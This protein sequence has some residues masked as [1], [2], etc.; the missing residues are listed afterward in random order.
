MN[1][2]LITLLLSF[3]TLV[4]I[5]VILFNNINIFGFINPMIYLL[6]LVIFRFDSDQTLF[7][8][9]CFI[10]GFCID[11][12]SQSGGAH[13]IASLTTGFLRPLLI[14]Y[15]FGVTSEIPSTFQNDSRITNKFLFLGLLIGIHHLLYFIIV[16]FNWSA[17][18]L[19][20]KNVI[21][22]SLFSLILIALVSNFYKKLNDS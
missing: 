12:L 15:S 22:T 14:K 3:V 21:L 7:I 11:F 20:L 5:Q 4:L 16:Y 19:I 17:Y 13:T 9:I 10:L 6:F 2:D 1:R 8:L 18:Y